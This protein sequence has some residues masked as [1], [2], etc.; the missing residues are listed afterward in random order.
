MYKHDKI[1][2]LYLTDSDTNGNDT[3]NIARLG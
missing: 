1:G 3:T 2:K